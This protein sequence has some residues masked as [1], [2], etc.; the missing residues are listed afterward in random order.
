MKEI[1]IQISW[2]LTLSFLT[3]LSFRNKVVKRDTKLSKLK[4]KTKMIFSTMMPKEI[5]WRNPF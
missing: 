1:K 5:K 3:K 2:M 4:T